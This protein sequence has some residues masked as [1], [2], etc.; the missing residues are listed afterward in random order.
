MSGPSNDANDALVELEE[1]VQRIMSYPPETLELRTYI[2]L[3]TLI[4]DYCAKDKRRDGK[5]AHLLGEELY[6]WLDDYIKRHLLKLH[7]EMVSQPD[8]A[9]TTFYL[10]RWRCY[11]AAA[12]YN[13]HLFRFLDR[14]WVTREV[15]EGKNPVHHI[16]SLH[17]LRWKEIIIEN[18]Q[19]PV[20]AMLQQHVEKAE[21]NWIVVLPHVP[22]VLESFAS[23]GIKVDSSD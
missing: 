15:D 6:F 12:V 22:E 7:T 1:G 20:N 4:H 5:G 21:D 19:N 13:A 14:H 17:L 16:Y 10:E 18:A 23:V 3:Y 2:R 11:K 9:L 8:D